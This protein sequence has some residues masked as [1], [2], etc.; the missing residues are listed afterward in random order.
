V[1]I[2]FAFVALATTL[3]ALVSVQ[4]A[5]A[6]VSPRIGKCLETS[7]VN[8]TALSVDR[9]IA[10]LGLTADQKRALRARL[11][12]YDSVRGFEGFGGLG[13]TSAQIG[14]M[15]RRIAVQEA[16]M[17]RKYPLGWPCAPFKNKPRV[18]RYIR[19]KL[20]YNGYRP[21]MTFT[22]PNPRQI[23]F[24]GIQDGDEQRGTLVKSGPR[25]I[26]FRLRSTHGEV[27]YGYITGRAPTERIC[28]WSDT[29][30]FNLGFV[31]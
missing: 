8:R 2:F 23:R 29:Y 17:R 1:R 20:L 24:H 30:T 28:Y 31:A 19:A 26:V 11:A 13:L 12:S 16:A 18:I 14:E 21:A 9:V 3:V 22:N 15:K 25:Q 10:D 4:A 27:C 5:P 7:M 6:A